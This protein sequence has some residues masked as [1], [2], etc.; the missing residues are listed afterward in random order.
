MELIIIFL[1]QQ[2]L[3]DP[4]YI[5]LRQR[6]VTG[7]EYDSFIEEFMHAVVRRYGQN[8]LIQVCQTLHKILQQI[9]EL[10][11]VHFLFF[12]L[13]ILEITMLSVSSRNTVTSIVHSMMTFRA[14]HLQ[15]QL[16]CWHLC[17]LPRQNCL[18]IPLCSKEQE[19]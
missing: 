6:R 16:V 3:D 12:S 11:F 8:T 2:L 7:E 1:L 4:L 14:Q 9:K 10:I 19:R 17:V 15:Q 5:G 18:K 13:K